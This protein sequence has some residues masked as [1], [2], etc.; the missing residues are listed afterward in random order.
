VKVAR[1]ATSKMVPFDVKP[2]ELRIEEDSVSKVRLFYSVVS[3]NRFSYQPD[4]ATVC[5]V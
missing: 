1:R 3:F 4:F 2:S 5:S